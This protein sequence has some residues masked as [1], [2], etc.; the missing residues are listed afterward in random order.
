ML[1][2]ITSNLFGGGGSDVL[3]GGSGVTNFYAGT[4]DETLVGTGGANNFF[5]TLGAYG[6]SSGSVNIDTIADSADPLYIND[7]NAADVHL[8]FS[9]T[10]ID[11][12]DTNVDSETIT[13]TNAVP[14]VFVTTAGA[15]FY[16]DDF[17]LAS[18]LTAVAGRGARRSSASTGPSRSM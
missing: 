14:N 4:G 16:D 9:P 6:A 2:A 8:V 1:G 3:T 10:E 13:L 15:Q 7:A 11:V 5:V 18:N 17:T 12:N